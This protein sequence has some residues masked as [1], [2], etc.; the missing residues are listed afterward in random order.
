M[1]GFAPHVGYSG[2]KS[3]EWTLSKSIELSLTINWLQTLEE[4]NWGN[5]NE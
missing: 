4:Q 5:S 1:H 2:T 3:N